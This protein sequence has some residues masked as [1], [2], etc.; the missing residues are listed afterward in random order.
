VIKAQDDVR[1]SRRRLAAVVV[2]IVVLSSP[3]LRD[4]D[5]FPLSTYPIYASARPREATFVTAHGQRA[6]GSEH[7]L[8]IDVIARTDDPLIAASR[9]G[10][11]VAAGRANELCAEIAARAPSDLVAVVVVRERHDVVDGARG[12]ESLLDSEQLARCTV[13]S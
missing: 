4:H 6:D 8:S 12:E 1:G 10:D 11:A 5:S 9:V 13:P 3:A 7:R 2:A